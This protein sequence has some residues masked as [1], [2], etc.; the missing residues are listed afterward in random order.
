MNEKLKRIELVHIG[1]KENKNIKNFA[2]YFLKEVK[3]GEEIL[4][5]TVQQ[6]IAKRKGK[7]MLHWALGKETFGKPMTKK[8][9]VKSIGK[10]MVSLEADAV[11][12]VYK[13]EGEE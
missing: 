3:E 4:Y 9:F 2:I 7:L 1:K 11:A 8:Q 6:D 12:L 13:E 10:K 5:H